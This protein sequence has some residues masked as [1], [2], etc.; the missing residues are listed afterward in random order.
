ME[1]I[2]VEQTIIVEGKYDKIKLSSL[3]DATI[4][5]TN[6][7]RIYKDKEKIALIKALGEKNGII[8]LT[9]SD[10]AGFKL[11]N[12]IRSICKDTK[13]Y[14]LYIPQITGKEKRKEKASKEGYL[15]V[16][17][18]NADTLREMF[19]NL[20][21]QTSLSITV[22][23][24]APQITKMDFYEDGLSGGENSANKRLLLLNKL[25]LPSYISTNSLL[26]II[27][28]FISY[29][30]YKQFVDTANRSIL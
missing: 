29:D 14:N 22:D 10:V 26:E 6:G 17:G 11:R 4:I 7:F 8:I 24:E 9:D 27:N 19:D 30:E 2:K 12:F 21:L 25:G 1:K 5:T 13:L 18:I 3:V 16:E 15:G 23:N 20:N 28:S